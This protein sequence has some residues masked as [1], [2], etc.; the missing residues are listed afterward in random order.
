MPQ[1]K[2]IHLRDPFVLPCNG[3]YYLYVSRG[4]TAWGMGGGLDVYRGVD[5]ENW[6]GLFSVFE[7][8]GVFGADRHCRAPEVQGWRGRFYMFASFKNAYVHR[9]T[10]VLA[11]GT[12]MGPFEPWSDGCVT[13]GEWE[14]LDGAFCVSRDG[15]PYMAFCHKWVQ[16]GNGEVLAAPLSE[17]L[18]KTVGAPSFCL[19]QRMRSGALS[20]R[21]KP[22]Q[23]A[24]RPTALSSG[25][26]ARGVWNA[27]GPAFRETNIRKESQYPKTGRSTAAFGSCLRLLTGTEGTRRCS[28]L[29]TAAS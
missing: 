21:T 19:L 16:A 22:A 24:M 11:A 23:G 6:E 18:K 4:A 26:P 27:C 28:M 15:R 3:V 8:D 25:V 7:H 13:P 14:C 2:D 5:L 12:P 20:K 9:G 10:A 1:H 17:D 29:L